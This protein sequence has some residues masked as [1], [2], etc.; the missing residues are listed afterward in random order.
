M[1]KPLY[2]S[3]P[4][5]YSKEEIRKVSIKCVFAG[6]CFIAVGVWAI[7]RELPLG[8]STR[9]I[10]AAFVAAFGE[11]NA[12]NAISGLLILLGIILICI[13]FMKPYGARNV[14]Q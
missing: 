6:L 12:A 2:Q 1:N 3:L 13:S 8:H 14:K 11:G 7:W 4:T 10:T 5:P 9:F